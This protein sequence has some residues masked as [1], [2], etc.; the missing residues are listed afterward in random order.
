MVG[1]GVD[2]SKL[3]FFWS[4]EFTGSLQGLFKGPRKY[5]KT[6]LLVFLILAGTLSLLAG[7]ACAVLLV[8]QLQD[9]SIGGTL[10]SLNGTA[11]S[12][13]PTNL[14]VKSFQSAT[15]LSPDETLYGVCPSG[16]YESLWSHYYKL[17]SSNFADTVPSYAYNLSGNHYYWSIESMRPVMTQTISLG[18]YSDTSSWI[19]QPHLA[20]S[21]VLEQLMKDW[22]RALLATGSYAGSQM[23]DRA[24]ASSYLLN[25]LVRVSCAP[26]NLLSASNHTVLF[27]VVE[28]PDTELKRFRAQD[29]TG[30]PISDNPKDH[31]QFSWIHLNDSFGPVTTGAVLQSAWN[32]DNDSRLV[33]GCSLSA[34]WVYAQVRSD[35]YSFWQGWY[36]KSIDFFDQYPANGSVLLN[37]SVAKVDAIVVDESWLNALTPATPSAG[38]GYLDWKPSTIESILSSSKITDGIE[39]NGT[40]LIDDW[41]TEGDDTRTGLLTSIIAS[42]FADGLSRAGVEQ[43]YKTQG[44]PSQW[45]LSPYEKEPDFDHV[46]LT[47]GRAIKNPLDYDMFSVEFTIS[48]LNYSISLTQELAMV[49]LFL[50]IAVA[51]SHS[52]WLVARTKS[53]AS[54]DSIIEIMAL[55]QNSKPAFRALENTAAGIQHS[56]TFSKKVVIR[57]TKLPGS[58]E[59]NHLQ[60]QVTENMAPADEEMVE[61]KPLNCDSTQSA[62]DP[63][64]E[65]EEQLPETINMLRRNSWPTHERQ[66]NSPFSPSAYS[67]HVGRSSVPRKLAIDW[68]SQAS[69]SPAELE[70]KEDFA[71]G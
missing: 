58:Q 56:S 19:V 14:S 32:S 6:Q 33:I 18:G 24:A 7:P 22:W 70:F 36:P 61:M 69:G 15:C 52:L 65:S 10:I 1:A 20:A 40:I 59:A 5:R 63:V 27:P 45:I 57:P 50:H 9:W 66:S 39:S 64:V 3:S 62:N 35:S 23:V 38:P 44:D 43:L 16:G 12:F 42:I 30:S 26:P 34:H 49:V 37:G 51:A 68:S 55:A 25:P 67:R 46:I 13:W 54:W 8:P 2:F 48:G 31:L 21:I 53:A 28:F 60:F 71:Y 11:D 4:R 29:I 47:N 17:D 41:Q